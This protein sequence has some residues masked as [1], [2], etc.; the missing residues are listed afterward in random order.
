MGIYFLTFP[1]ARGSRSRWQA[2]FFLKASFLDLQTAVFSL[3]PCAVFPPCIHISGFIMC[4]T[5]LF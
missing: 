3:C 5:F 4:P 1:E 2:W